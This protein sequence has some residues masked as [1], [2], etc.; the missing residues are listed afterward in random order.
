MK[1]T[2]IIPSQYI[3]EAVGAIVSRQVQGYEMDRLRAQLKAIE[4]N[5]RYESYTNTMDYDQAMNVILSFF[6][7]ANEYSPK[8]LFFNADVTSDTNIDQRRRLA[9]VRR[10]K[11]VV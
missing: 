4:M 5:Q 3:Y 7:Q 1:E 9:R 10:G 2:Y 11:G 8:S 6:S